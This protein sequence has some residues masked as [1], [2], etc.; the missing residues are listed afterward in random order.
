MSNKLAPEIAA[1]VEGPRAPG[2]L[3]GPELLLLLEL[4][5]QGYELVADW[6]QGP[7]GARFQH[8]R[9]IRRRGAA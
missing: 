1:L 8:R 6:C 4:R 7:D 5:R 2:R 3:N 9:V